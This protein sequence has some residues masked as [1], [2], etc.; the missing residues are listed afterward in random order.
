MHYNNIRQKEKNPDCSSHNGLP[1][2]SYRGNVLG[3][4]KLA[5]LVSATRAKVIARNAKST[6]MGSKDQLLFAIRFMIYLPTQLRG[7]LPM[8]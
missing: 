2:A 7:I 4:E 1:H 8:L 6:P 3:E 5:E